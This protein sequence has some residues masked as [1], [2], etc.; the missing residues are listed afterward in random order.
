MRRAALALATLWLAGCSGAEP[1]ESSLEV[2]KRGIHGAALSADGRLAAVGSLTHGGSLWNLESG[3]RRFNWSHESGANS[4]ITAL[5]FAPDGATAITAEGSTVVLWD[6]AKGKALRYFEAPSPVLAAAL[7]RDGGLG[8]L[9]LE[10]GT[11]ALF[12]ARAGGIKRRFTHAGAVVAVALDASGRHAMTGSADGSARL[13]D[14]L[15]GTQLQRWDYRAEVRVVALSDDGQRAF[16]TARYE[17]SVIRDTGSGQPIAELPAYST[18]IIRGETWSAA[19]FSADGSR[20]L[21]GTVD[22]RVMLWE[23]GSARLI[24]SWQLPRRS[25]WKAAGNRVVAGGFAE[26]GP[27]VASGDGFIHRLRLPSAR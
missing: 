13:W 4:A 21:C 25:A 7:S 22:G 24:G 15:S 5:G 11:A 2:A 27:V 3:E 9:G 14:T 18:R 10:D 8:L 16:S 23:A 17:H 12:D 20:L 1:P 6:T 26:A 19:R